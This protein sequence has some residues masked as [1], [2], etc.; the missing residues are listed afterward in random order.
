M[1]QPDRAMSHRDIPAMF[2]RA[3]FLRAVE[4]RLGA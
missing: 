3:M 4:V 1:R 2:L